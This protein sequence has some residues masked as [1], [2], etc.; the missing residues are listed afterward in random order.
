VKEKFKRK[1]IKQETC[2][3]SSLGLDG[4]GG[5]LEEGADDSRGYS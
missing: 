5:V 1:K 4:K 3:I 2:L